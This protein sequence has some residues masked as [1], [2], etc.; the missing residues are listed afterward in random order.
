MAWVGAGSRRLPLWLEGRTAS[1]TSSTPYGLYQQLLAS[2]VGV[3]FDQGEPVV[4]PALERALVAVMGNK[5][6]EPLLGRMMGLPGEA[7]LVTMNAEELRRETFAA[8]SS[9]VGRLLRA[10]PG[11]AGT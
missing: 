8:L 1:Y 7:G 2:W 6:L 11:R 4:R 9:L 5:N 10:G 3:A